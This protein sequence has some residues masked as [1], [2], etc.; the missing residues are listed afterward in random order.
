MD[1]C[2]APTCI[3]LGQGQTSRPLPAFSLR[4]WESR[5]W[6]SLSSCLGSR[7]GS[8]GD[9][10]GVWKEGPGAEGKLVPPAPL[11]CPAA[12]LTRLPSGPREAQESSARPQGCQLLWCMCFCSLG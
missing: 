8:G 4:K 3:G 1:L 6:E 10:A 12:L 11:G 5:A 9:G 2:P 7:G